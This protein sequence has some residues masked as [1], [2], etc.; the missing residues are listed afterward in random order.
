MVTAVGYPV[1]IRGF[2]LALSVEGLRPKTIAKY[3][4]DVERF[5]AQAGVAS[6][7]EV[8]PSDIRAYILDL[9]GRRAA[10][11]VYEAQ[12]GLRRFFRFLVREG[13]MAGDPT[14]NM[15]PTRY[16]VD[17]QPTYSSAEVKR[18]LMACNM[19]TREGLRDRALVMVLFDTG[20]RE[21]EACVDDL[22]RLGAA[23]GAGRGQ[24]RGQIRAAGHGGAAG[25]G[26]VWQALGCR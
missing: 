19:R 20:V 15:K 16:R 5:A 11:T 2:R 7:E 14:A 25:S 10:K 22:A 1:L 9:Q 18:L 4:R 13:E 17:P 6:P 3:V 12:L 8:T 21:G 23:A 24:D 26:A